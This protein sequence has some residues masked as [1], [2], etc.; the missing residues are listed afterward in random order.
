MVSFSLNANDL[1]P[2]MLQSHIPGI[3]LSIVV[4]S[5]GLRSLWTQIALCSQA[6]LLVFVDGRITEGFI[7]MHGGDLAC[8]AHT[9]PVVELA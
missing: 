8:R 5:R 4:E 3:F 7:V 9:W 1:I 6:T 2:V